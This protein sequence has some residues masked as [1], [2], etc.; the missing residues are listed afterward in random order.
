MAPAL[1]ILPI[2]SR[3]TKDECSGP[4]PIVV[5]AAMETAHSLIV[6]VV[7]VI[8]H[9]V[10]AVRVAKSR[11]LVRISSQRVRV[12]KVRLAQRVSRMNVAVESA[13]TSMLHSL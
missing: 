10:L 13:Q 2:P 5:R 6:H 8:V 9:L 4:A 1:L 7:T 11:V 3:S 12:A